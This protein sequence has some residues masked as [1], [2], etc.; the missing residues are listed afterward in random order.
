MTG[1][2]VHNAGAARKRTPRC[3]SYYVAR[4]VPR[5]RPLDAALIYPPRSNTLNNTNG[6][7]VLYAMSLV[8]FCIHPAVC[9]QVTFMYPNI[10]TSPRSCILQNLLGYL[11]AATN[12][13]KRPLNTLPHVSGANIGFASFGHA[14]FP[15]P[16]DHNFG[17]IG[18][19]H[20]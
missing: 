1:E 12:G 10:L 13:G 3:K 14:S 7:L 4:C 11:P 5:Q 9:Q 6:A 19:R 8:I 17:S 18:N 20:R 16:G 15:R 2:T